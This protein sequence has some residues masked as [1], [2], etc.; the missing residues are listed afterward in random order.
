MGPSYLPSLLSLCHGTRNLAGTSLGR[1]G[2]RAALHSKHSK[3]LPSTLNTRES[4]GNRQGEKHI[5]ADFFRLAWETTTSQSVVVLV[6]V[7][8]VVP[9]DY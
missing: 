6:C 9:L 5:F 1:Q 3:H 4:L 8:C 7:P 2:L